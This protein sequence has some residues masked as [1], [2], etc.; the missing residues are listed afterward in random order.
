MSY[1]QTSIHFEED[2]ETQPTNARGF[3]LP[4]GVDMLS[5][6]SR[7]YRAPKLPSCPS[8]CGKRARADAAA[9]FVHHNSP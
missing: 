6:V 4:L 9:P 5:G 7:V 3:R 2:S 8:M 1:T